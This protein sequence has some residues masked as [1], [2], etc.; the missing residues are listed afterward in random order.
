MRPTNTHDTFQ[1]PISSPAGGRIR[2][3]NDPRTRPDSS[4]ASNPRVP[5]LLGIRWIRGSFDPWMFGLP[6][7]EDPRNFEFSDFGNAESLDPWIRTIGIENPWV[8][9]HS[10]VT[11][12]SFDP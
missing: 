4:G 1:T 8:L 12:G 2:G 11:D 5:T 6:Q 7:A 3:S 10:G 9:T